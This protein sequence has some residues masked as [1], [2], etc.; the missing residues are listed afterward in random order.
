M[1][2]LRF[3]DANV[4]LRYLVPEEPVKTEA[5]LAL[6]QQVQRN[7]IQIT[8][9]EAVIAEVV[10]V[11]GSKRLYH[12]PR[13]EIKDRLHPILLLPGLKLPHRKY[14]LRALDYYSQSTLDFED[15]LIIAQMERQ[16]VAELYSYDHDFD[17][18]S[19][20]K[21]LEP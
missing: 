16:R 14:Y 21:R 20:I 15:C 19:G 10:F 7:Q 5:C 3:V 9:S 1:R 13:L 2:P 6:F 4:F 8:T 12:L 18:I 17:V 11:L